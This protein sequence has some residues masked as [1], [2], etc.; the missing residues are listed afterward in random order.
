M[1]TF[2]CTDQPYD[3]FKL[4][5]LEHLF[6]DIHNAINENNR[7]ELN[8]MDFKVKL[9]RDPYNFQETLACNV[10]SYHFKIKTFK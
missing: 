7:E 10:S 5:S 3:Y 2:S 6:S 9:T 4:Y 8:Y 1:T